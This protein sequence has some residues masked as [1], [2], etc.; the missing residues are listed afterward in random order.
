MSASPHLRKKGLPIYLCQKSLNGALVI[1][2]WANIFR[3][4]QVNEWAVCQG[5]KKMCLQLNN[6]H[7]ALTSNCHLG[8]LEEYILVE[9]N[10]WLNSFLSKNI[11]KSK[12]Q[13]QVCMVLCST[14]EWLKLKAAWFTWSQSNPWKLHRLGDT[15][16]PLQ[17]VD[18]PIF[19][20]CSCNVCNF[21]MN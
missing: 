7:Q 3:M 18:E 8:K 14:W 5:T 19:I 9:W 12:G 16:R 11:W 21:C 4:S 6:K 2:A 17:A 10:E 20:W 13:I 15:N 1:F